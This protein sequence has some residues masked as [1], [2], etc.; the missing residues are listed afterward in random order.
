MLIKFCHIMKKDFMW[1]ALISIS[2]FIQCE[3]LKM[4]ER[5]ILKGRQ[6]KIHKKPANKKK[7]ILLNVYL[8]I[9]KNKNILSV[10]IKLIQFIH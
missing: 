9:E 2:L 7:L 10:P 4:F 1:I 5:S 3:K 6:N 8:S